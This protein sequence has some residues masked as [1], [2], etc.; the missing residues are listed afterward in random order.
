MIS[1]N[2]IDSLSW[3]MA[4]VL[5]KLELFG[6]DKKRWDK[7]YD[8][9]LTNLKEYWE[10]EVDFYELDRIRQENERK[11]RRAHRRSTVSSV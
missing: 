3:G 2:K 4:A 8:E 5:Y 6:D 1:S 11:E 7:A 10:I 9:F